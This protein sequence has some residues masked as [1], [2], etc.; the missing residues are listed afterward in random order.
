M[1][2]MIILM[3]IDIQNP[4]AR[5][6]HSPFVIRVMDTFQDADF[7]YIAMEL[8]KGVSLLKAFNECQGGE[9]FTLLREQKKSGTEVK[10]SS[11]EVFGRGDE[12]L[13]RRGAERR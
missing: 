7:L 13:C 9:L 8:V 10:P 6:I 5:G 11:T 2:V 4:L 1:I 3:M 12:V